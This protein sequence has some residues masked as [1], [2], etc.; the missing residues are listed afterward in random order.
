M[1]PQHVQKKYTWWFWLQPPPR[2]GLISIWRSTLRISWAMVKLLELY[3]AAW[4]HLHHVVICYLLSFVAVIAER[5]S[6]P[7]Q[8][9][10][11][12][13]LSRSSCKEFLR[14]NRVMQC[15]L[16]CTEP[17]FGTTHSSLHGVHCSWMWVTFLKWSQPQTW[18]F[19]VRKIWGKSLSRRALF[20]RW[21]PF[22]AYMMLQV[23][24]LCSGCQLLAGDCCFLVRFLGGQL[25]WQ[26]KFWNVYAML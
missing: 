2:K 11:S 16:P 26:I 20:P 6:K 4:L 12:F 9:C 13:L 17:S 8:L 5:N 19:G 25:L 1:Q 15:C 10:Y 14:R 23:S 7:K 21:P 3:T 22:N 18:D 24:K